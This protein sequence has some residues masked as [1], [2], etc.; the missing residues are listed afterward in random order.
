MNDDLDQELRRALQPV[1]PGDEFTRAVM[2]RVTATKVTTLPSKSVRARLSVRALP[3]APAAA[4]ASL[5]VAIFVTHEQQQ[6][7][8]VQEGL[9]ARQELLE[10]LRVTSEKLDIAYQVVHNESNAGAKADAD[11]GV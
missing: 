5:L 9:R 11:A 8:E 1:D 2:A 7:E 4:A 3:W 6:R 10:A